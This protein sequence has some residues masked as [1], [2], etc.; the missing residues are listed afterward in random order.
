MLGKMLIHGLVA[1]AIIGSAAAVYAQAKDNGYLKPEAVQARSAQAP[2]QTNAVERAQG[3][4]AADDRGYIVDRDQNRGKKSE[5][6][7]EGRRHHDDD[8]D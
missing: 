8:D 3:G 4:A 5:H 6:R 2:A 1:A 7:H